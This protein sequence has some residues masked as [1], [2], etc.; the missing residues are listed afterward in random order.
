MWGW[1][2]TT[3]EGP[4][5][6]RVEP[7]RV[8]TR[9][10]AEARQMIPAVAVARARAAVIVCPRM[11]PQGRGFSRRRGPPWPLRVPCALALVLALVLAGCAGTRGPRVLPGVRAKPG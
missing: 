6:W 7:E 11:R 2:R 10:R 5:K 3:R 1:G 9:A 8:S 4:R